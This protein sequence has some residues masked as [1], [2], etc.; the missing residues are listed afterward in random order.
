MNWDASWAKHPVS[1][2]WKVASCQSWSCWLVSVL[3]KYEHVYLGTGTSFPRKIHEGLV[4]LKMSFMFFHLNIGF[5]PLPKSKQMSNFQ[6]QYHIGFRG[7]KYLWF[8]N[9]NCS[10]TSRLGVLF[11]PPHVFQWQFWSWT[12]L[13]TNYHNLRELQISKPPCLPMKRWHNSS[14]ATSQLDWH[15]LNQSNYIGVGHGVLAHMPSIPGA[16]RVWK[17]F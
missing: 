12:R 3:A 16:G 10:S 14:W 7:S 5:F 4:G 9:P 15:V 11:V 17:V 1:K 2:R 8:S 6:V 13:P